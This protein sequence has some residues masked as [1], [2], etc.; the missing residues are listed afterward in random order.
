MVIARS[1]PTRGGANCGF[2]I[3]NRSQRSLGSK[4]QSATVSNAVG[5]LMCSV[6]LLGGLDS[7]VRA[8]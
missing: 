4:R 7:E 1:H 3:G 8:V 5:L 2:E 6:P